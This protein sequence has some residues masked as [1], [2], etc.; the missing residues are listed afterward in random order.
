MSPLPPPFCYDRLYCELSGLLC[1]PDFFHYLNLKPDFCWYGK[2][3]SKFQVPRRLYKFISGN[4]VICQQNL[5][6]PFSQN[7]HFATLYA[8]PSISFPLP[9]KK[10]KKKCRIYSISP[11]QIAMI[12]IT[13]LM[14]YELTQTH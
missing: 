10:V 5:A 9:A 8:V 14:L 7:T 13:M 3:N 2:A 6:N 11:P 12:V 4:L 1:V